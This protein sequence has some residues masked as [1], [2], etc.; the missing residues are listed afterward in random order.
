MTDLK[1]RPCRWLFIDQERDQPAFSE[2]HNAHPSV[3]S[4]CS[5]IAVHWS[6]RLHTAGT[7]E[8][9]HFK[10]IIKSSQRGSKPLHTVISLF[11]TFLLSSGESVIRWCFF[12]GW[13]KF[14]SWRISKYHHIDLSL[15]TSSGKRIRYNVI[16]A[17]YMFNL[18]IILLQCQTPV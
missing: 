1:T 7:H 15:S 8:F 12:L 5:F 3:H 2:H 14:W 13:T 18:N 6:T 9:T 11:V 16:S 10:H 17:F 4:Y